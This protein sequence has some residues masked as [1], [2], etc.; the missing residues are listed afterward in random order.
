MAGPGEAAC[1]TGD[2][3]ATAPACTVG[4]GE[5]LVVPVTTVVLLALG[6]LTEVTDTV[7]VVAVTDWLIVV[8]VADRAVVVTVADG[9]VVVG[10]MR[11]PHAHATLF[12][13]KVP[14]ARPH[15]AVAAASHEK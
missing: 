12:M 13:A 9:L 11:P 3:C 4:A 15:P 2:R 1:A 8:T 6:M 5:G 10:G 7:V 14:T